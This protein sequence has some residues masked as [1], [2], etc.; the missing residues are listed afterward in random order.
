M[1]SEV[2]IA[3]PTN[4]V[5]S[6]R[7]FSAVTVTYRFS[8][9][10][11]VCD[12]CS[13]EDSE[14]P[15][16]TTAS[17]TPTASASPLVRPRRERTEVTVGHCLYDFEKEEWVNDLAFHPGASGTSRLFGSA[18]ATSNWV[19]KSYIESGNDALDWG[20]VKLNKNLGTMTGWFGLQ[21]QSAS[22]DSTSV[23]VRG[24]PT[25]RNGTMLTM[26]GSITQSKT[27][28][29]CCSIDTKGGQ[30][31]SPVYLPANAQV[32]GNHAYG[33]TERSR[34]SSKCDAKYSMGVRLTRPLFDI[35]ME[36]K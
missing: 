32:I 35:L 27:N 23:V 3:P 19:D 16:V 34:G 13:D 26:S 24:Y 12:T 1:S 25:I 31:C 18:T 17:A 30:S 29:L 4:W 10:S 21:T 9:E 33:T 36:L 11:K 7:A 22:F 8:L 15:M 2:G 20:V 28:F 6:G 5:D 14:S